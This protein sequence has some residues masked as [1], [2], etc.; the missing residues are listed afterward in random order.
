MIEKFRKA[1]ESW[2]MRGFFLLMAVAFTLMWSGG[3]FLGSMGSGNQTVITVGSHKISARDFYEN[4]SRQMQ[5]I[6]L[7]TGQAIDDKKARD[8]GLYDYIRENMINEMLINLEAK[9]LN[10]YVSDD[11]IRHHIK[12]EKAFQDSTGSFDKSK[13][14]QFINKIGFEENKY[15]E[16]VR[17]ELAR[18]RLIDALTSGLTIPQT[19]VDPLYQWQH[20]QRQISTV[21]ITS[22]D[23]KVIIKP[24]SEQLTAFYNDHKQEFK[25]PEYREITAVIMDADVFK[26]QVPVP[27]DLEVEAAYQARRDSFAGKDLKAV[28]NQVIDMLKAQQA[29]DLLQHSISQIDDDLAAGDSLETIADKYKFEVKTLKNFDAQGVVDPFIN[30]ADEQS[31]EPLREID[32]AILKEA[33]SMDGEG[34]SS[35]MD[36]GN[37]RH[38]IVRVNT[39]VLPHERTFAEVEAKIDDY[40]LSAE[41]KQMADGQAKQLVEEINKGTPFSIIAGKQKLKLLNTRISRE[42]T[43]APS[44]VQLSKEMIAKLFTMDKNTAQAFVVSNTDKRELIVAAINTIDYAAAST[45]A[46]ENANFQETLQQ[47]FANDIVNQYIF[48]LRKRFPV[49]INRRFFAENK[50]S[51][52]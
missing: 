39:V 10:V 19:I 47:S 43:V 18:A 16:H 35:I 2:V 27:T 52:E 33:Y 50:A 15:L 46:R 40:W 30:V 23:F 14:L 7:R 44:T 6:Q 22:D 48:S 49:E 34:T 37:G 9:R 3:D 24:T 20:Q 11:Y 32:R 21:R 45:D 1:S 4:L 26:D 51:K 13:F 28:K 31:R 38:Y 12:Q 42:G 41:R 8:V 25:A 29:L 36:A 5:L 17:S